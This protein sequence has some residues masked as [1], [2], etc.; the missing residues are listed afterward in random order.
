MTE[1]SIII[2]NH[3]TQDLTES[4]VKSIKKYKPKVSYEIVVI[5]N[6]SD[7]VFE[8]NE[9]GI[10]VIGNKENLG[11]A[12]ANNQAIRM[13][14]GKYILLLNSDT[15]VKKGSIDKLYEFAK[16]RKDVGVVTSKLL[17]PD[18]STQASVFRLPTIWRAIRQYWFGEN[19]VLDKYT[20]DSRDP[21]IVEVAV[22]ASFLITPKALKKVGM[23]NEKYFMY[24]EDFDY[25]RELKKKGLK[26][27][28]LPSSEVVHYH[29]ASGNS[30]VSNENQWRRLIPGSKIYHGILK[31]YIITIVFWLGQKWQKL[32]RYWG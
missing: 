3:N 10:K 16:E 6:G 17:N 31:H 1:L 32:L 27:Y 7:V 9:R 21:V 12:K 8:T 11:F 20:P 23:L 13:A 4:C 22:M 5:D 25:C 2:I 26:V 29:G 19:G 15:E 14:V 30:L 18:G 24:F 28:Y